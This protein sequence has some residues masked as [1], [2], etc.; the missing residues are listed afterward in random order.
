MHVVSMLFLFAING[1]VH[2]MT[3]LTFYLNHQIVGFSQAGRFGGYNF[4]FFG[5][6]NDGFFLLGKR[7]RE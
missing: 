6:L 4:L 7:K 3:I 1:K 5:M 2:S